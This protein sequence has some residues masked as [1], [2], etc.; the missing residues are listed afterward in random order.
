MSSL[1]TCY[2]YVKDKGRLDGTFR[3]FLVAG[4]AKAVG[5][6]TKREEDGPRYGI[7]LQ[8]KDECKA[9][10]ESQVFYIIHL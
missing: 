2:T 9:K 5:Y 4:K 10:I 8:E 3:L 7:K 6:E 1:C